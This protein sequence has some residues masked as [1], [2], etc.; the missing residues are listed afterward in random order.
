MSGQYLANGQPQKVRD[1]P[2][3]CALTFE[4]GAPEKTAGGGEDFILGF[5][6]DTLKRSSPRKV[7]LLAPVVIESCEGDEFRLRSLIS[8][9]AVAVLSVRPQSVTLKARWTPD[10]DH[11]CRDLNL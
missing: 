3:L 4:R 2:R 9:K 5:G 11:E 6:T 1:L 8:E 10:G 7:I